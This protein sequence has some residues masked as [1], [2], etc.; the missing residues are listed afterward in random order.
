EAPLLAIPIHHPSDSNSLKT[1]QD[2]RIGTRSLTISRIP[3]L[4]QVQGAEKLFTPVAEKWYTE[5]Q[6]PN[7]NSGAVTIPLLP[8]P[9]TTTTCLK[10]LWRLDYTPR[11]CGSRWEKVL[12]ANY[13]DHEE[14]SAEELQVTSHI[15]SLRAGG[16][17]VDMTCVATEIELLWS[18]RRATTATLQ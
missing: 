18:D 13:M 3:R 17:V 7:S 11:S 9:A 14:V 8:P 1:V 12:A 10:R 4:C 15:W 16:S 6:N 5:V 2:C